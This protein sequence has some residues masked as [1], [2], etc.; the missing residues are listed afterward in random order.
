MPLNG[1]EAQERFL[2]C[3]YCVVIPCTAKSMLVRIASERR[4]VKLKIGRPNP[5]ARD[6]VCTE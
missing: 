4:S 5:A 3:R 1:N 6:L 2:F